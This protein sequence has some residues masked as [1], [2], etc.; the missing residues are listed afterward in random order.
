MK[1]FQTRTLIPCHVISIICHIEQRNDHS[2][3]KLRI[4]S[5]ASV[6]YT[7]E[8]CL[9]NILEVGASLLLCLR[10]R[11]GKITVVADIKQ[12]FLQ[13]EMNESNRNLVRCLW[14]DDIRKEN[15]SIVEYRF[16]HLVFGLS[17]PFL[18]DA[19]VHHH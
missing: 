14:F 15:P 7:T 4:D 13:I 9:N 11:T 3:T 12:A 17:S 6:H 18:L 19:T 2:S 5:D 10:F 1:K 16:T 8:S